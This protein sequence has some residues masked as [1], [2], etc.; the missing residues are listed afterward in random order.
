MTWQRHGITQNMTAPHAMPCA[1]N[2]V[3]ASL[4]MTHGNPWHPKCTVPLGRHWFT[5]CCAS[6][7][8]SFYQSDAQIHTGVRKIYE[9]GSV[10]FIFKKS[11]HQE[12]FFCLIRKC[13]QVLYLPLLRSLWL[14][15][16][17]KTKHY[18]H[19]QILGTQHVQ[20]PLALSVICATSRL[21]NTQLC[22][23]LENATLL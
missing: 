9:W 4:S 7:Q 23:L 13:L 17:N 5:S 19:N 16:Q 12:L 6:P 18:K 10:S 2:L 1:I 3:W 22:R 8:A 14:L 21:W 15:Q 20:V 11:K